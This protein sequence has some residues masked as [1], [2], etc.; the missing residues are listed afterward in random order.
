[1]KKLTGILLALML[2]CGLLPM[3]ALAEEASGCLLTFNFPEDLCDMQ[4]TVANTSEPVYRSGDRVEEGAYL[5]YEIINIADG[6]RIKSVTMNGRDLSKNF[7]N[8]A[9]GGMAT[10]L[11]GDVTIDVE[12]E[13]IPDVLPSV[14]SVTLYMGQLIAEENVEID[15]NTRFYGVA[16]YSDGVEYPEYFIGGIWEYSV[17]GVN[18]EQDRAWGSN[19]FDYWPGWGSREDFA[20][21]TS[22]FFVNGSYDLRLRVTPKDLYTTG[23]PV[24]SNVI[25]ING[26]A[27]GSGSVVPGDISGD[28]IVDDSDVAQLLWHTLFP[29]QYPING[30][31]DFTGDDKV[32][33]ED[34]AYLL[35]HTLFPEQYPIN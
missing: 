13:L 16:Q 35:W 19:R 3:A 29:E 6:Y 32:D 24:L 15:D 21:G 5:A 14:E 9:Y 1:M 23:E 7:I 18:W 26:G 12:L 31:A 22:D 34:V 25:H 11:T 8:G 28:G 17:D 4:A 20:P 33:D 27:G 2:I 30:A 10:K